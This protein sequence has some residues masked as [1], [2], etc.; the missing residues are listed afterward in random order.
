MKKH[1]PSSSFHVSPGNMDIF[2]IKSGCLM[3]DMI[4]FRS[5][6]HLSL[7]AQNFLLSKS[8]TLCMAKQRAKPKPIHLHV[9][10]NWVQ[11]DSI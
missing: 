2:I 10:Y 7:L 3:Y 5:K 1:I 6:H 11:Q 4:K 9:S 8:Q